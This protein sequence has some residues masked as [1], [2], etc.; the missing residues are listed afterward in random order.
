MSS[1]V[2]H[3]ITLVVGIVVGIAGKYF[4]DFFTD[5]RHSYEESGKVRK[6]FSEAEALMPVLISEMREDV[7]SDASGTKREFYPYDGGAIHMPG[8][9]FFYDP[10][11]HPDIETKLTVLENLGY[12]TNVATSDT[13]R[14]RMSEEFV[15]MLKAT[16]SG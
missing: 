10:E 15:A 8:N 14:F 11:K 13:A 12:I 9:R 2:T 6:Q 1:F 7:I 16:K 3:A 4:A 5:R